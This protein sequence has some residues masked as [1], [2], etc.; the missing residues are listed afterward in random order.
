MSWSRMTRLGVAEAGD[1]P[2]QALRIRGS[3][4]GNTIFFGGPARLAHRGRAAEQALRRS[5]GRRVRSGHP[6]TSPATAELARGPGLGT[7]YCIEPRPAAPAR[8]WPAAA[9]FIVSLI[10]RPHVERPDRGRR[11]LY[12]CAWVATLGRAALAVGKDLRKRARRGRPRRRRSTSAS[13]RR[14]ATARAAEPTSASPRATA[15]VSAHFDERPLSL[16]RQHAR[17]AHDDTSKYAEASTY[18]AHAT[19]PRR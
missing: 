14:R 8:R 17:A 13:P 4:S 2:E 16:R 1:L 19:A 10:C 3:P 18:L 12:C 7:M 15:S 5:T 11:L 6:G 9:T